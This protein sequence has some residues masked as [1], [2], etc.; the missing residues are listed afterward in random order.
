[1][2]VTLWGIFK[3]KKYNYKSFPSLNF[4]F[5]NIFVLVHI[6]R[7][8]LVT[9][10]ELNLTFTSAFDVGLAGLGC[11]AGQSE[12]GRLADVCWGW[13]G[14]AGALLSSEQLTKS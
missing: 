2:A 6:Y 7:D 9:Y 3:K 12:G 14:K 11:V 10:L 13:R 8:F 1:M 4:F 5:L